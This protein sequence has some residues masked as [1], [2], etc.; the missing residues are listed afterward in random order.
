M[1]AKQDAVLELLSKQLTDQGLLIEAG[2]VSLRHAAIPPEASQAQLDGMRDAFFAGAQH[3]FASIMTIL[4]PGDEEPTEADMKRM[5]QI[6]DELDKF[7]KQLAQRYY[8][9]KGSA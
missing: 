5:S 9:T 7:G 1:S 8:P 3:L 6:A 4:D 2:W